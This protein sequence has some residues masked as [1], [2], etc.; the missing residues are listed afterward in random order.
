MA[1]PNDASLYDVLGIVKEATTEEIRKMFRARAKE[2]HPDAGGDPE[3]FHRVATAVAVLSDPLRRAR[4]DETGDETTSSE[5]L[6][7]T[8]A[9]GHL[10]RL[11]DGALA[12]ALED[13]SGDPETFDFMTHMRIGLKATQR[14]SQ[15]RWHTLSENVR[16]LERIASRFKGKPNEPNIMR[17]TTFARARE[18]KLVLAKLEEEHAV[19][20][21]AGAL[22]ENHTFDRKAPQSIENL[23]LLRTAMASDRFRPNPIWG[24]DATS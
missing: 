8:M 9:L 12:A 17:D 18:A 20:D 19:L 22:L 1:I 6:R 14:A 4:Y 3:E 7:N 5:E 2:T 21:L 15:Q 24:N 16:M 11:F 13:A 23:D 10:M